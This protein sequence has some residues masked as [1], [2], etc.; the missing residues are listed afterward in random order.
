AGGRNVGR[1]GRV[2]EIKKS[3]RRYRSI[4]TL[5]DRNGNRF[6]T[7]LEYVFPI[8]RDKPLITLPEGAW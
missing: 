8:G 5:E 2:L 4:V 7:S 3:I 1:V 6:Q